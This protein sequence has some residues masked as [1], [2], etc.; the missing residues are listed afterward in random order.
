ME[1]DVLA[2]AQ[3]IIQE[4]SPFL[5]VEND[6]RDK[7]QE[8]IE[9]IWSLGYDLFWH[10]PPM[11]NPANYANDA[12]NIFQKIVSVNMFCIAK[13]FSA[14]T[15]IKGFSKVVDSNEYPFADRSHEQDYKKAG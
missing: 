12:E 1:A 8:L 5:Y 13:K 9:L 14:D 7:S 6:R 3:V 4:H 10:L 11:Y 15:T 2:G